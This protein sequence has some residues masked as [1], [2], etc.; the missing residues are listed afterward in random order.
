MPSNFPNNPSVNQTHSIGDITW[1]WNGVAWVLYSASPTPISL[2]DLTDV[3]LNSP[4]T[5][6]LL[7]YNGSL[8][9]NNSAIDGG[10]F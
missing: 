1:Q 4:V 9:T 7:K 3:E 2:N 10:S 5:D 6:N 8:W